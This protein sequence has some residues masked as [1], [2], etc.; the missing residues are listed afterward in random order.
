MKY[1]LLVLAL[2][3]CTLDANAQKIGHLNYGN[4][5]EALPQ[6][7]SGDAALKVY[8][9][10]LGAALAS[11][12]SALDERI[13]T[14]KAKFDA[15]ELT[16]IEADKINQELNTS[17]NSLILEQQKAEQEI[18]NK[19]RAMLEPILSRINTVIDAYAKENGYMFIF[20]ESSGF[21]MYDQPGE[22]LTEI[23]KKIVEE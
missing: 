23:I 4:L 21:I 9:D 22:D 16:R 6:V 14:S 17:Q 3:A 2:A 19:R 7:T 15:G 10:S 1:V 11:M 13:K 20:D 5:L 18:R 12:Q 8:Q